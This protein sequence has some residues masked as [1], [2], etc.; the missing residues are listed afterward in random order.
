MQNNFG[1]LGV[2]MD[3]PP[4]LNVRAQM[5]CSTQISVTPPRAQQ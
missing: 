4:D 5:V 1:T 2:L 3:K